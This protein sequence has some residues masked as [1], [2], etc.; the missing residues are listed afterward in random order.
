MFWRFFKLRKKKI[1]FCFSQRPFSTEV[2]AFQQLQISDSINT[3]YILND[4]NKEQSFKQLLITENEVRAM[5]QQS[6]KRRNEFLFGRSA[7]RQSILELLSSAPGS[8]IDNKDVLNRDLLEYD[9]RGCPV[10][11]FGPDIKF[12]ISHRN[13]A[14]VGSGVRNELFFTIFS[15]YC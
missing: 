12:S 2:Y 13:N 3:I 4:V 9:E 14:I 6:L 11:V 5:E 10:A 7:V 1:E 15:D 8:I